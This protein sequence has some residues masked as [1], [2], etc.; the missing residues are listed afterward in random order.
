MT[1]R[2]AGKARSAFCP[3]GS[4]AIFTRKP[5]E[6]RRKLFFSRNGLLGVS[7]ATRSEVHSNSTMAGNTKAVRPPARN[8]RQRPAATGQINDADT[9][10]NPCPSGPARAFRASYNGTNAE[11]RSGRVGAS[12]LLKTRLRRLNDGRVALPAFV[13][14]LDVLKQDRVGIGV[15]IGQRH[16][17]GY[18]AA[19]HLVGQRQLAG[20]VVNLDHDVLAEIL[21]RHL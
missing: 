10:G 7:S 1:K 4:L 2:C 11:S 6:E 21:Q 13:F 14:Q 19:E 17:F 16:E 8:R 18:P 20:F 9:M 15:E 5:A 3:A 12:Q